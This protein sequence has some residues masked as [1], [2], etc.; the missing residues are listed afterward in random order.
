MEL[1]LD[2]R[3]A[4]VLASSSGLGAAVARGLAAEGA[5]VAVTSRDAGRGAVTRD[6]VGAE[7]A[8]TGDLAVAGTAERFVDE[9]VDALDGLDVLVVNTG[10]AGGVGSL[11]DRDAATD[12]AAYAAMLRPAM[13][14]M[15]HAAPHLRTSD[16]GRIVV[17]TAR[18]IAEATNELALSSVFR[19]A[20]AAAAR[21]MALDFAPEVTVN[22][23]VTGQFDTAA[24]ARYQEAA[25]AARGCSPADIRA[26]HI[27]DTPM[28]R[29]GRPEELGDVVTFLCSSRASFVTGTA[30][31][32]D[33]GSLR[34]L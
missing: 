34:G 9:A 10:S 25:A 15:R 29:V 19:S 27:A 11:L 7:V 4:L 28:Q 6:D 8:L 16:Q 14:A 24:L 26:E 3:R 21:S 17:L 33:G 32:V 2:G 1:G 22:V 30:I 23:V 12:E 31:R 5:R 18:S 20:V 13:A